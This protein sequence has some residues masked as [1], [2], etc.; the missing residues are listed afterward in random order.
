[1]RLICCWGCKFP[2]NDWLF[3]TKEY[4]SAAHCGAFGVFCGEAIAKCGLPDCAAVRRVSVKAQFSRFAVYAN[5][6]YKALL[7]NVLPLYIHCKY[8]LISKKA[9]TTTCK[10]VDFPDFN[11][12][13]L[14]GTRILT[15]CLMNKHSNDSEL[16]MVSGVEWCIVL[17]ST[18]Y[19]LLL[20]YLWSVLTLQLAVHQGD[21]VPLERGTAGVQPRWLSE[22]LC[23]GH[24]HH[25][26]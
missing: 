23:R 15:D 7:A 13:V 20:N 26:L 5:A 12:A 21:A 17:Y 8:M 3:D 25:R 11:G 2:S 14:D 18:W 16:S 24:E 10:T 22:K 19:F 9:H 6:G 1:M 4:L